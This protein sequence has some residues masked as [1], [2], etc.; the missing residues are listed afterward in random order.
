MRG[1]THD[2]I[3]RIGSLVGLEDRMRM[4]TSATAFANCDRFTLPAVWRNHAHQNNRT[5]FEKTVPR[6]YGAR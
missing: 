6:L 3:F 4:L 5:R 1:G 2:A